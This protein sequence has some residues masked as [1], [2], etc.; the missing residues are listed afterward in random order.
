MRDYLAWL[1]YYLVSYTLIIILG[2]D[3]LTQML[4]STS[5]LFV[6]GLSLIS[7]ETS[8]W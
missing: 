8:R 4:Y 2:A 5:M 1:F 6:F 7:R 3:I